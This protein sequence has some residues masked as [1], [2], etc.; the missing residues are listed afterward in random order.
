MKKVLEKGDAHVVNEILRLGR[1]V[2]QGSVSAEK[3]A[4]FKKRLKVLARFRV[5]SL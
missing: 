2:E 1:L 3:K 4:G 5:R